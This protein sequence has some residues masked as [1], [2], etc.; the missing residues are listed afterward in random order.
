MRDIIFS[1]QQHLESMGAWKALCAVQKEP[2]QQSRDDPNEIYLQ[3]KAIKPDPAKANTNAY[4]RY[5]IEINE[6]KEPR[7]SMFTHSNTDNSIMSKDYYPHDGNWQSAGIAIGKNNHIKRLDCSYWPIH[8]CNISITDNDIFWKGVSKSKSIVRLRIRWHNLH[9]GASF[10]IITSKFM[11]QLKELSLCG[12][13]INDKGIKVLASILTKDNSLEM[14]S[15]C[16]EGKSTDGFR[17]PWPTTLTVLGWEALV[18]IVSSSKSKLSSLDIGRGRNINDQCIYRLANALCCKNSKLKELSIEC[19]VSITSEGWKALALTLQQPDCKLENLRISDNVQVNDQVAFAFSSALA[20]NSTLR[21]LDLSGNGI[22]EVGFASFERALSNPTTALDSL[23][24]S[25]NHSTM[26]ER[27]RNTLARSLIGNYKLKTLSITWE[28]GDYGSY[29]QDEFFQ[30]L[31]NKSSI[32]DT[33]HSNHTLFEIGIDE[34]H[35]TNE[36]KTL[37]QLNKSSTAP[38]VASRIK[39]IETHLVYVSNV[40]EKVVVDITPFNKMNWK[41]FPIALAWMLRDDRGL[42]LSHK[43]LQDAAAFLPIGCNRIAGGAS[44]KQKLSLI[45]SRAKGVMRRRE[46]K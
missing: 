5:R 18:D 35:I 1:K 20:T 15:L 9:G 39:I 41:I 29:N 42:S 13:N 26:N 6:Y 37:L 27:A 14:L 10:F 23:D 19:C 22:R 40:D 46:L 3:G 11:K 16:L 34:E 7:L 31:C 4:F 33:Y 21:V 30:L 17:F 38:S 12:C 24:L 43:F 44:K 2:A 25:E 8:Y 32:L 28:R 36:V 45:F